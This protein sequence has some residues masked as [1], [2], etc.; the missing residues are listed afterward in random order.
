MNILLDTC[1]YI[2]F[3]TNPDKLSEKA[4]KLINDPHCIFFLSAISLWE[5]NMKV[6]IG[7]LKVEGDLEELTHV[8]NLADIIK[9]LAF[10]IEDTEH[11]TKMNLHHRDPFD[12]MLV[13]Q[14]LTNSLT[15]LS[16]D[17][18]IKKYNIQT[19]W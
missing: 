8:Q 13:C 1:T 2:W 19:I 18:Y 17:P 5:I 9:P 16:P 15:I 6:K 14:A 10:S 7:K 12:L 4:V 11:I 3:R